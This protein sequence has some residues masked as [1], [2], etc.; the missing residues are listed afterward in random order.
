MYIERLPQADVSE[1]CVHDCA[2]Q[3]GKP[4]KQV[5]YSKPVTKKEEKK[6]DNRRA[7]TSSQDCK[8]MKQLLGELYK[9][10]EYL[11]TLLHDTGWASSGM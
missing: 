1:C 9:D 3:K 6:E 2:L 7:K 11:E 10:K 8:T 4:K 5:G